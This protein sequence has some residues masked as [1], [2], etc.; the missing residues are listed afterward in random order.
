[1]FTPA[2][3]VQDNTV[4][5]FPFRLTPE[6]PHHAAHGAHGERLAEQF[7]LP[8]VPALVATLRPSNTVLAVSHLQTQAPPPLPSLAFPPE[9]A[10]LVLLHLQH[11]ADHRFWL[12]G[13]E[14][15]VSACDAGAVSIAHLAH[16]PVWLF[17]APLD[18][19]AFYIPMT[20][21]QAV[22]RQHNAQPPPIL[23][24]PRNQ[25]DAT[26]L[27]LGFNLLAPLKK[28]QSGA[29]FFTDHVMQAFCAYIAQR[30]GRM[31]VAR[32]L[33]GGL[34]PRQERQAKSLLMSS[35]QTGATVA[36]VAAAVGLSPSYFLRA[37][38]QSVGEPPRR[39]LTA[40]KLEQAKRYLTE[41]DMPLAEVAVACG[42]G[43]QPYLTR[44]FTRLVGKP[45]GAWRRDQR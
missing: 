11:L 29:L 8:S 44:L 45:P 26:A 22:A 23:H 34:T 7:H 33:Q 12:D 36:E 6:R 20:A 39:W 37:F 14:I 9:D 31:E 25:P 24:C 30:Y 16:N 42:F 13:R 15:P 28:G 5:P 3:A 27:Q 18:A 2:A 32:R 38:R 40:H 21:L 41:T 10:Y 19:L 35:I 43:D 1:M 17:A 4:A